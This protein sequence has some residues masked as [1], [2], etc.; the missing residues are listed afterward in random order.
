MKISIVMVLAVGALAWTVPAQ[1]QE[2]AYVGAEACRTC[3]EPI[4]Q[5]W[6][7]TKHARTVTRLGRDDKQSG[8]CNRCHA[9]GTPEA[10]ALE[11]DHLTLPNVQCEACHG[12]GKLH[13]EKAATAAPA[14]FG[15][16]AKPEQATCKK[17]HSNEGPHFRGFFYDGMTVF[18]HKVKEVK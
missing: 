2:N 12:M 15:V 8:K 5:A 1:A 9:T 11:G 7:A 18:V 16:T 6:S 13:T 10:L 14:L 17:C 4:F 3:H